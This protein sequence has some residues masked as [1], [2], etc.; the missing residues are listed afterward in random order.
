MG[1][2][3]LEN[4]ATLYSF[5]T[6]SRAA[7]SPFLFPDA[8]CRSKK[9]KERGKEERSPSVNSS[10]PHYPNRHAEESAGTHQWKRET[11][12]HS[13]HPHASPFASAPPLGF[14]FHRY[15]LILFLHH[16]GGFLDICCGSF[17]GGGGGGG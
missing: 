7:L 6:L 1:T 14:P 15:V 12:W 3:K 8:H 10:L 11:L 9:G 4:L 16:F 2:L 13:R 5:A 17:G